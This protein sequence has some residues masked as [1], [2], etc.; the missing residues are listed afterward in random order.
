VTLT[1][2]GIP[3]DVYR[4]PIGIREVTIGKALLINGQPFYCTGFGMHEDSDV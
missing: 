1:V 2:G 4:Q 3:V